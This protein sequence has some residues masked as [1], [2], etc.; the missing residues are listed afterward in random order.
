[1]ATTVTDA[2][3]SLSICDIEKNRNSLPSPTPLH[4]SVFLVFGLE[5]SG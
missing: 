3:E 5:L 1:M 4:Y 2:N